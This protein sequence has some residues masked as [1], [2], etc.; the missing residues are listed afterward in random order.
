MAV[1]FVALILVTLS[2][3]HENKAL[4]SH[5]TTTT[6]ASAPASPLGKAGLA[7]PASVNC[8]NKGGRVEIRTMGN[9]GEYGVCVFADDQFCEEWALFKGNCPDGGVKLTGFDTEAQKYCAMIGGQ[10][11]AVPNATCSLPSGK[12]CPTEAVYNGT[13]SD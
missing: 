6:R 13:C 5:I 3:I 11:Y 9:G 12:I 7:N 1:L 4:R 2:L 10:T 8:V